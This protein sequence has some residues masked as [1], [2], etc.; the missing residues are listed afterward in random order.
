MIAIRFL[1][2]RGPRR[3]GQVVRYDDNSAAAIVDE[4]AAEYVDAPDAA[5]VGPSSTETA[6]IAVADE[7]AAKARE[8][9]ARRD[10]AANPPAPEPGA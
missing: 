4:G 7:R 10:T 9:A 2:D 3:K 5:H 6:D 8:R 1:E